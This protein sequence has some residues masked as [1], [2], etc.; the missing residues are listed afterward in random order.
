[1]DPYRQVYKPSTIDPI[2]TSYDMNASCSKASR[3]HV[4]CLENETPWAF[5]QF[6]N[7]NRRNETWGPFKER[8]EHLDNLNAKYKE[9][10]PVF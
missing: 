3:G 6:H 7:T 8:T 2:Y 10:I 4:I 5:Y 1:M 9:I